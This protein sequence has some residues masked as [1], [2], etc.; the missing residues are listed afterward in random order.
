M[1]DSVKRRRY[2]SS[3]R[4]A[5][6]ARTRSDVVEAAHTLFVEH[7]YQKTTLGAVAES[8]RVSVAT[9]KA[10]FANKAGL[11]SAVRD[12]ALAGDAETIPLARRDWYA[13]IL[14]ETDPV[15]KLTAFSK[16]I[17]SIHQ[18]V[19]KL[20]LLVRDA[21]ASVDEMDRLWRLEH[22][23]RR[24]EMRG[25]VRSMRAQRTLRRTLSIDTAAST[26]WVLSD[27]GCFWLLTDVGGWS[28]ARYTAWL[29][30]TMVDALCEEHPPT[31]GT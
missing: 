27:P 20:H 22:E 13:S 24:E 4:A 14:D 11:V 9:V 2:D 30:Q 16:T 19:A 7:G 21:G 8:A 1:G 18:R 5:A 10:L 23:Q 12:A 26:L 6:A 17:A 28:I 25:V 15:A 3:R 29:R 31:R